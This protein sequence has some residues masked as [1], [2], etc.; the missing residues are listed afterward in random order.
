MSAFLLFPF[1]LKSFRVIYLN[2]GFSPQATIT[3]SLW[4][5]DVF[6]RKDAWYKKRLEEIVTIFN[7][8]LAELSVTYFTLL[9]FKKAVNKQ[10]N[11][12]KRLLKNGLLK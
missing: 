1:L 12:L 2:L 3:F 7:I 6:P 10:K 8:I 11:T 5:Q 9:N 4:E